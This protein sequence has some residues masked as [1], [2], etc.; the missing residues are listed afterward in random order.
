M[1]ARYSGMEKPAFQR[2]FHIKQNTLGYLSQYSPAFQY[3]S[4]WSEVN[5][6]VWLKSNK[7]RE[8]L[9][10][11]TNGMKIRDWL[12]YSS[13]IQS[14]ETMN[15]LQRALF[16]VVTCLILFP[17]TCH[18]DANAEVK[19]KTSGLSP[20]TPAP[21][22][23][24]TSGVQL[25]DSKRKSAV[26]F[27]GV[28]YSPYLTGE[29]PLQGDPP[30]NDDRYEEHL[31]LVKDM[32]ANYLHVFP[33]NI[34][35]KFFLA[36]D[37]TDIVYG[38]DIWIPGTAEDFL[39]ESYLTKTMEGIK[40]TIDHVYAVGRPDRLVLF[41]VGDELQAEAVVRTD[42][43]HPDV[44]AFKGKYLRVS[45]RTPT[46]IALVRLIDG[47][48]AYELSRYGQRHLYCHTSWTHIGPIA[49]RPDL[50]VPKA[51]VLTPDLG[52]LVCLN[53]YTYARGVRTSPPGSVTGSSYQ[54]YLEELAA[55][56]QKPIFITQVGL[57]TSPFEP[58]PW[59]PGF[60]GH[61]VEDVPRDFT[62]I[63]KDIRTAKGGKKFCGVSFFELQDE[64][65][66][67]GETPDDSSRH[68][69]EDPEEWFGLYGVG[70][71]RRLIPKGKIP[72]TLG[73]LY[74]R[75]H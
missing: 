70:P 59:V 16:P 14:V 7:Q 65:W 36:L 37:K 4:G 71:D 19:G 39:A 11:V 51:N 72:E 52:D 3:I 18:T 47:A 40:K 56:T 69:R 30:G 35:S 50:E 5:F 31:G 25:I 46:E 62:A 38:Q 53:I 9:Q 13:L 22:R 67:S 34:P 60:G 1:K 8:G 21:A 63:W 23:F 75:S 10:V 24:V 55:R 20:E 54:G 44:H 49:D 66:K 26:F 15:I 57:S 64:W 61:K 6:M 42:T 12:I 27:R 41:S 43:R 74:G 45:N 29:T 28:G 68:D 48:I 58:K 32:N 17:F 73:N 33:M 2:D